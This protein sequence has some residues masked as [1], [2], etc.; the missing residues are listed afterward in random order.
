MAALLRTRLGRVAVASVAALFVAAA[1]G[2]VLLWP[3]DAVEASLVAGAGPETQ[4]AEVVESRPVT[5]RN[6]AAD[7]CRRLAI[8]LRSGRRSGARS[9][10]TLGD[11]G[12][13]PEVEPGAQLRVA[14]NEV[15]AGAQPGTVDPYALVEVNRRSPMLWLVLAFAALVIVFGRLRERSPWLDWARAC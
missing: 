14:R 4:Q 11:A 8:E 9:F 13:A 5:C 3:G 1:I 15:P 6:P 7:G 2:I 12:P 10:L